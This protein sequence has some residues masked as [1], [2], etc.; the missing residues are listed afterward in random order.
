M[1]SELTTILIDN[2]DY[3]QIGGR[4]GVIF[5]R[6][7]SFVLSP[8]VN[9]G[10]R[11]DIS[12]KN[13]LKA[14]DHAENGILLIRYYDTFLAC[15]LRQFLKEMIDEKSRST[16]PNKKG[17]WCFQVNYNSVYEIQRIKYKKT[18]YVSQI[19]KE[20]LLTSNTIK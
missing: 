16:Y 7:N 6:G 12:E 8:Y 17:R 10:N 14:F 9:T 20:E 3:N 13:I 2:L 18:M 11:F 1:E 4:R 19:T 5:T 15:S